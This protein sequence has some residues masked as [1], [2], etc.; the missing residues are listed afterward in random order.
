MFVISNVADI[1]VLKKTGRCQDGG[2]R[3]P[4]SELLEPGSHG[5]PSPN[6]GFR[7]IGHLKETVS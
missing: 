3:R 7:I 2:C 5:P 6:F 1:S 4:E